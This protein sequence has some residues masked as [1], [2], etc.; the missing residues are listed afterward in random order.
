M[1]YLFPSLRLWRG[2]EALA[3][4]L[5]GCGIVGSRLLF[6]RLVNQEV[7]KRRVLVYGAG[8]SATA[9][10]NLRRSSDRRGFQLVGFV[11]PAG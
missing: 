7:F 5:A 3:V 1:F 4:I 8:A 10:A 9:V 6:A 11:P 2:V